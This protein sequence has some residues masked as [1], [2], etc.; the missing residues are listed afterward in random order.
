MYF[1]TKSYLKSTHNHTA[2]HTL[3]KI[4]LNHNKVLKEMLYNGF[5]INNNFHDK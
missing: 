2:K 3:N 5:L 1:G 4:V